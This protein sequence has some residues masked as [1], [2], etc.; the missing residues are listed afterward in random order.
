MGV[1]ID[2]NV[3]SGS[4]SFFAIDVIHVCLIRLVRNVDEVQTL[5]SVW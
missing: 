2:S 5:Y 1:F 4:N 3:R